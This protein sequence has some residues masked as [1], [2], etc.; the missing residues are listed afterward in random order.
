MNFLNGERRHTRIGL[1]INAQNT[2]RAGGPVCVCV[3]VMAFPFALLVA[4]TVR[5]LLCSVALL[6]MQ[7]TT[8]HR[9]SRFS[10]ASCG[11]TIVEQE[12]G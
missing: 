5:S 3:H 1:Q 6:R 9:L 10:K 12:K 4:S 7:Y 8:A 2:E 11:E